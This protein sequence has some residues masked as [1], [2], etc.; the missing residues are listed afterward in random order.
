[1]AEVS[2]NKDKETA[3]NKALWGGR[4]EAS[5]EAFTQS[6]GASLSVDRKMWKSDIT[7]SISH[8]RMLGKCGI[9]SKEDAEEIEKGL[10]EVAEE[11]ENGDFVFDDN[12]EDIHMAVESE[13]TRKI[14]AAGGRLHTA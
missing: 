7:A 10:V 9:I 14:G 1:M 13:L 12:D 6:F 11:I 5:P 2:G 3:G 4:F 8:A